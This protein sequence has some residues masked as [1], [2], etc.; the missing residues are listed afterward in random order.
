MG[1]N[2]FKSVQPNIV[3]LNHKYDILAMFEFCN[4]RHIICIAFY[5]FVNN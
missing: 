3:D 4:A 2:L 1:L 5:I